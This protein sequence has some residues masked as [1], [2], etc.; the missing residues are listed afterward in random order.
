MLNERKVHVYDSNGISGYPKTPPFSPSEQYPE[1]PFIGNISTDFNHV[2]QGI[3]NILYGVGFDKDKYG[4][5]DWNPLGEII[6]PGDAVLIKP[7]FVRDFHEYGWDMQSVITHGSVIRAILDYVFIALQSSGRIIIGDAPLQDSDF[8]RILSISALDKVIKFY[9]DNGIELEVID[10]RLQKAVTDKHRYV[11]L[12]IENTGDPR[13]YTN[14][15]LGPDSLLSPISNGYPKYR[16]T[17]YDPKIV[18]LYHSKSK[19]E[20]MIANT[21]LKSDVVINIPKMKTHRLAGI[22]ATL[23]NLI[24]IIGRKDCLAHYRKNSI[25]EGG[26]EYQYKNIFKR[27]SHNVEEKEFLS[28]SQFSKTFFRFLRKVFN[29]LIRLHSIDLFR[30]GSWYGNDTVWRTV[31]DINRILFYSDKTGKLRENV[32]R[33][34][35]NLI[36]GIVSGEKD[37][38]LKPSAKYCGIMIG[39]LNPVAVEA[40]A[41]RMMGFDYKKIPTIFNSFNIVKYPL[42]NFAPMDI[43]VYSNHSK[44]NGIDLEFGDSLKFE[45]YMGWKGHIELRQLE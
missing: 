28:K 16:V 37:G 11:L 43:N 41:A 35:F 6:K 45:P 17:N 3:R 36:D 39:G 24:G 22:T 42:C 44:W 7:N 4:Q 15:D 23:K 1:Y 32:Q 34:V 5:N 14:V 9:K 30:G 38:P 19:N 12:Q 21:V 13:G 26:D 27:A 33:R 8:D 20:Y 25:D 40:V 2:Y 31:L 10:F 18:G 29:T